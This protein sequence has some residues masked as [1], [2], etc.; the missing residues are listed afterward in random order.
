MK[1]QKPQ[2]VGVLVGDIHN[3]P[4]ARIKYGSFFDVLADRLPLVEVY[5]ASLRGWLR[6]WN[7]LQTFRPNAHHWRERFYKNVPAFRLRSLQ[8]HRHFRRCESK[9]DVIVQVGVL[10]NARWQKPSP[11]SVIYTD[12]TAQLA[13]QIPAAGRSPFSDPERQTWLALERQAFAQAGHIC[14]RSQL[15]RDSI[16]HD[17]AIAPERVTVI[18]GGIN[19]VPL[20]SP[21]EHGPK[22]Q[23]TA[24]FV[25]KELYRKGGDVLLRAFAEARQVVPEARLI[26]L[27]A[28]PIP[29]DLPQ[30]GVEMV[31]PTWDREVIAD[32][33]RRAD[34]FVLPSRLETWGD[35]LLKAMGYGLPCIGVMGQAM[36]EIIEPDV[37]GWLVPAGDVGALAKAL[38]CLFESADLRCRW[39]GRGR[40]QAETRYQWPDVVT[41]LEDCI[42]QAIG[43]Q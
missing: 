6:Y 14:T 3:D 9:I 8:A 13:A 7:A 19:F 34:L 32:L 31:R 42:E 28:G 1:V 2:I 4:G 37:T 18:G 11:P 23:P 15:V 40:V 35:V 26:L 24:L 17:Y 21:V 22:A 29:S 16:I 12:Y 5:D 43:R 41:R 25:G 27:T 33:Y 39:G 38:V 36:E 20:P 30:A 10:L